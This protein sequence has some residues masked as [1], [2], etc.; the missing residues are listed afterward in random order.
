MRDEKMSAACGVLLV[1]VELGN[2]VPFYGNCEGDSC[3]LPGRVGL[4]HLKR[5]RHYGQDGGHLRGVWESGRRSLWAPGPGRRISGLK[6]A[7]YVD[8]KEERLFRSCA[9]NHFLQ[10]IIHS[11][12]D[13]DA[14][15]LVQRFSLNQ[16]DADRRTARLRS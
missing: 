12:H 11:P 4:L 5:K 8:L 9:I 15:K 16:G 3:E 1:E 7:E 2:V 6:D 10:F 13:R 14:K